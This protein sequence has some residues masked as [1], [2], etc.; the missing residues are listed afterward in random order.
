[1]AEVVV[2]GGGPVG[3]LLAAEL[4]LHNIDTVVLEK[5]P[6]P[7]KM[8]KAANMHART[9][10]T[11]H[12]RGLLEQ[13]SRPARWVKSEAFHF[14]GI[15]GLDIKAVVDEGPPIVNSPQNIAEQVFADRAEQL[16]AI[17]KRGHTVSDVRQDADQVCLTVEGP[18]GPYELTASYVVAAD[19]SHSVVRIAADIDFVGTG[20]SVAAL[21][22]QVRLT[23]A[24][25][26]PS[27]WHRTPR[28]WLM[29]WVN[30]FGHSRISTYDFRG[31]HVDRHAP[32]TLAEFQEMVEH[33]AGRPIPMSEG[34]NLGRYSDTAKQAAQYR[35]GR[36]FV[37]GDAAHSHFP[38]GGQ[39][40]NTGLQDAVNLG[41]KLAGA[42][43]GWAPA[44]LLDT[45]H[46][47]RH[48]VAARVIW[49]VRA[50]N[51]LAN[52]DPRM[53]PLRELFGELMKLDQV[54]DYLATMLSGVNIRYE[55]GK[56]Q[57]VGEF[58][59]DQKLHTPAGIVTIAE[60]L[61]D[62]KA[63]LI[64]F[65]DAGHLFEATAPWLDRVIATHATAI[66]TLPNGMLI[67]P[68]GYVVWTGDERNSL[69]AALRQWFGEGHAQ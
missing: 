34:R 20:P 7:D 14:G 65:T 4:A 42:V 32:V 22:G 61:H 67:R 44:E 13:V 19:G 2:V 24:G 53:D 56:G 50:Q 29:M 62:G 55:L 43:Q 31:P 23:E 66:S 69:L 30:P 58:A 3:M 36:I 49:N 37:A 12:R 45:Y 47:E 21:S 38:W 11:M 16:G 27:G 10:Q 25:T 48:P 40:L 41:W 60:L 17:I 35:K 18:E 51:A 9:A 64:D 54:N 39:G 57:M 52:P 63:V 26:A 6:R 68:D 8:P 15:F 33:I 28:G 5:L 59:P 1:M 46:T